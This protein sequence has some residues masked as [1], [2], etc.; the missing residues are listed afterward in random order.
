MKLGSLVAKRVRWNLDS[1]NLGII[2]AKSVSKE[3]SWLVLWNIAGS[4]KLQEHI[5]DALIDLENYSEEALKP[6]TCIST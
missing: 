6:R 2:I 5:T 1:R 4:Y 3:D